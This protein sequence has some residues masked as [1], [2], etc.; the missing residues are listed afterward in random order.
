M[1]RNRKS[2]NMIPSHRPRQLLPFQY[3]VS[4]LSPTC[5][6]P[7]PFEAIT[8]RCCQLIQEISQLI[9]MYLYPALDFWAPYLIMEVSPFPFAIIKL[10]N[11]WIFHILFHDLCNLPLY[12]LCRIL[13]P[14]T[15]VDSSQ[16][17]FHLV[18]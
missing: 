13:N 2:Q 15:T 5:H 17:A 8:G 10:I 11:W 1:N 18:E 3:L 12:F 16:L 9:S 14:H 4:I 6:L 7:V